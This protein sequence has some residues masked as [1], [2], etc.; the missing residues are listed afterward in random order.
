MHKKKYGKDIMTKTESFIVT[1]DKNDKINVIDEIELKKYSSDKAQIDPQT[2]SK[3]MPQ[4]SLLHGQSVLQP[5]YNAKHLI[6][7]LDI[8]SYHADCVEAV[9][10]VAPY[11][12]YFTPVPPTLRELN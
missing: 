5:K 3:Q 8:Y 4:D 12:T 11:L 6:D 9:A 7:L 1:V 10:T 2:G